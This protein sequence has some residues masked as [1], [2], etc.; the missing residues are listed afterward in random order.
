MALECSIDVLNL[1][2]R[3]INAL[4]AENILLVRDL[5]KMT[6]T[7]IR[8]IVNIGEKQVSEIQNAV[9]KVGLALGYSIQPVQQKEEEDSRL[10][11]DTEADYVLEAYWWSYKLVNNV[12]KRHK[13]FVLACITAY[14]NYEGDESECIQLTEMLQLKDKLVSVYGSHPDGEVVVELTIR[15]EF[16]NV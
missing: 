13:K 14:R 15:E 12:S 10:D 9:S 1:S 16:V 11:M 8:K 6:P 7:E 2:T 4:K 5:I 3:C